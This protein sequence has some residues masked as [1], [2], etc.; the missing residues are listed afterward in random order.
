MDDLKCYRCG[1]SIY[2]DSK[3]KS[4]TGR[5][6]PLDSI[7]KTPHNCSKLDLYSISSSTQKPTVKK[8]VT[9]A[10]ASVTVVIIVIVGIG[11]FLTNFNNIQDENTIEQSGII[12]PQNQVTKELSNSHNNIST[13]GYNSDNAK[14]FSGKVT[15]IIDGD[16]IQVDG[17]SIRLALS[18]TPELNQPMGQ[19]AKKFVQEICPMGSSVT[20]D[21][22]NGQTQGSY[23]RIV[24]KVTCNGV[25]LNQAIIEKGYGHLSFV[26]CDDSEFSSDA[27]SGCGT[28]QQKTSSKSQ[29]SSTYSNTESNCDPNYSGTCIPKKS[30]DLDCADV[31]KNIKVTGDDPHGLDRDGDGIGCEG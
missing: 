26:H 5:Y 8:S 24:A 16:T 17:K 6:I 25:N 31:E 30:R 22:D 15:G 29:Y 1:K 7:T 28:Q 21:E 9:F 18:S 2:F 11:A 14:Y 19:A 23:G 4:K 10:V 3:I 27:W 13:S 12:E 20:V